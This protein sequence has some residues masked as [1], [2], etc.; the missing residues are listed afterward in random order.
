MTYNKNN[1]FAKIIRGEIPS[2][3][4]YEDES[5]LAFHDISKS[6][7]V[8]V[9]VI[10]KSEY[11]NFADFSINAHASEVSYFFKKVAEIAKSLDAENKGFR[12]ITNSGSDAAQSVDHFHVHILCG[13]QMGKLLP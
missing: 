5:V 3:K 10:P 1:I 4:I 12:I 7:P 11:K 13:V 8:H 6:A 2:S 9:L